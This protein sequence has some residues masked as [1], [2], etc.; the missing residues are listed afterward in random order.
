MPWTVARQAP[1]SI[2]FSRQEYGSGLSFPS[3]GIFPTQG[4]NLSLLHWQVDSLPLSHREAWYHLH[5]LKMGDANLL[6][7]HPPI[8]LYTS[9]SQTSG[10]LRWSVHWVE[11][12]PLFAIHLMFTPFWLIQ[13][14]S[15]FSSTIIFYSRCREMVMAV[16][17]L[18]AQV[19]ASIHKGCNQKFNTQTSPSKDAG[20]PSRAWVEM[21]SNVVYSEILF[22]PSCVPCYWARLI[23]SLCWCFFLRAL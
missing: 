2:G 16:G 14:T 18:P 1:L 20:S 5:Q 13:A 10:F 6:A 19:L 17:D 11:F 4:S 7:F 9:F 23:P 22:P 21:L 8:P 15:F 12:L 3:P